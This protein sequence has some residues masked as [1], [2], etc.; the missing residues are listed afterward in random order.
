[1]QGRESWKYAWA[2]DTT[3]E[4][5]AK[6]KTQE[7]GRGTFETGSKPQ[8]CRA[9]S[10]PQPISS[11][12][13]TRTFSILDAPGHKHFV[14][15]MIGGASQADIAVLVI[16]AR[17]GEFET[18]FE[19]GGQTRE[20]AVL[21]KTAGVRTLIVAI[22]KMDDTTVNWEKER[23]VKNFHTLNPLNVHA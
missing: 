4:E 19:K 3:D 12:A 21:A 20:H 13:E 14:P 7:C 1:M 16:S 2:L 11:A 6:G 5:R 9:A 10:S 18:G 23:S 15:H 8:N 22:N 17:K